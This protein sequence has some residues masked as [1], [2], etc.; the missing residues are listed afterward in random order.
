MCREELM[1]KSFDIYK[2]SKRKRLQYPVFGD[3]SYAKL[4]P[5][6]ERDEKNLQ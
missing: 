6:R 3:T 4:T 1:G 5:D 2:E